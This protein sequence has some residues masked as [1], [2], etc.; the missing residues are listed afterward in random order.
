[1]SPRIPWA[2]AI[3]LAGAAWVLTTLALSAPAPPDAV[4]TVKDR[5]GF[6]PHRKYQAMPGKTIGV[7]VADVRTVMAN[8]GRSGP[9]DAFGLSSGG[10][11]YRWIYVPVKD[12]PLITNF[13]VRAGEKGDQTKTY[14][15]LSMANAQT[16]KQ[17]DVP[18][19]NVLVEVEVNDGLGAPPDE[20][21]VATKMKVLDGTKDYPLKVAEA[22]D[23]VR[24]RYRTYQ[25]EQ[26]KTIDGAMKEAQAKAL[27]DAKPT[28]PRETQEMLYMTWLPEAQRLR[29]HFRTKIT[30][31]A[32]KIG[33]GIQ[34]DRPRPL[35]LPPPPVPP[36][37]VAPDKLAARLPPP[38][39]PRE[40]AGVLYGTSFRIE[41]GMAYEVSKNGTVERTLS[42]PIQ[43]FQ[44]ELPPPPGIRRPVDPVPPV[45]E[46]Q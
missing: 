13:T 39:P 46:R 29:V 15:S 19:G 11:S 43:S 44:K 32:Y 8:E 28:G 18:S 24:Q 6:I 17:W 1:M 41:L 30:D 2:G 34:I 4:E 36:G 7:L 14:P 27:K 16:V 21:F 25:K 9:A 45:R 35:P 26:E 33:Y 10:G 31:G 40:G 37:G 22:L 23:Q 12:K 38:P 42:L 3:L 20:G 5:D